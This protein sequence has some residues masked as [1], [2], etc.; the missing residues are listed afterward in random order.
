MT[1]PV[2]SFAALASG[3]QPASLLDQNFNALGAA[4][5]I[6]CSATGSNAVVLTPLANYFTPSSYTDSS[7]VF[8]WIQ[9]TTNTGATTIAV[10]GSGGGSLG[11]VTAYKQNG[12]A[13]LGSGDLVGGL[14]YRGN[15][16][17]LLNAGA[18]GFVVTTQVAGISEAPSDG[19]IYG[20]Q[21]AAWQIV[22]TGGGGGPPPGSTLPLMDGIASAGSLTPYSR[23]DHV[24]PT[25]TSR[26]PLASPALTGT[27]TAPTAT[28]GTN[29]TQLAT[30]A[31]VIANVGGGNN[32]NSITFYTSSQT[33]TIPANVTR[34]FV[35]MWGATGGS[36]GG[37]AVGGTGAGGYLEKYL[38]GLTAGNTLAYTQGAAGTAGTATPTAGGNGGITTLASGTQTIATLTCNA[39]NGSG[40]GTSA[41]TL[42]GTATGGDVNVT[43][44]TGGMPTSVGGLGI[45]GSPGGGNNFFSLGATG[46]NAGATT[47]GNAGNPGGLK[48]TWYP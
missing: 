15:Y 30:T 20:R 18:G 5:A 31:F 43:G 22:P 47:A 41:G 12:G 35:Q 38:T 34:A 7:P 19:N 44:Q 16:N 40:S 11:A 1:L 28:T 25:D 46:V 13:P 8:C 27:P 3:D 14:S 32:P 39:S 6:A 21:N 2:P 29:T 23:S 24:H 42:G 36:G 33:I 10:I 48:I 45:A 4:T 26:A 17:H 37:T 9:Q